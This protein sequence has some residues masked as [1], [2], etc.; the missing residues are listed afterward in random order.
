MGDMS[1]R[2]LS[3]FWDA[4]EKLQTLRIEQSSKANE[5]PNK[6]VEEIEPDSSRG[7]WSAMPSEYWLKKFCLQAAA[8]CSTISVLKRL[9]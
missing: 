6:A 4:P 9:D 7:V 8:F 1:P 3:R 2:L 5:V